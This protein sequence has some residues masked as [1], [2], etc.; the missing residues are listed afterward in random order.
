M[1]SYSC[2]ERYTFSSIIVVPRFLPIFL[3]S[4]IKIVVS[5]PL[6]MLVIPLYTFSIDL[7]NFFFHI[8][9]CP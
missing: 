8:K 3:L 5:S 7:S 6:S 9:N 4:T 2:P 1:N